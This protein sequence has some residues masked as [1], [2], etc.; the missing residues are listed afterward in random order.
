M[1]GG[2]RCQSG[3]AARSTPASALPRPPPPLAR[4]L[5]TRW[6]VGGATIGQR[7]A[8]H[9]TDGAA[10]DAGVARQALFG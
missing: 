1:V 10:G 3:L 7:L 8:V 2:G 6:P 9:D 5:G 4:A